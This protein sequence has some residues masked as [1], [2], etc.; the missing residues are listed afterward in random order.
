MKL[1][2]NYE[3]VSPLLMK[4]FKRGLMTN[5]FLSEAQYKAA[6]EAENLQFYE[7]KDGIIFLNDRE[8]FT[9]LTY[10]LLSLDNKLSISLPPKT[11]IE[12]VKRPND[13]TYND[14]LD[15]WKKSGFNTVLNR[16]RL[17]NKNSKDILTAES[18][19]CDAKILLCT[20]ENLDAVMYMLKDNFNK[21][22][23]C[24]PNEDELREI[25][26]NQLIVGAFIDKE[27]VGVLH[28]D[29]KRG[30]SEIRHLAVNE[31]F[32]NAS[33]GGKLISYYHN[34]FAQDKS[35][36]WYA[37]KNIGAEGVY[38]RYNYKVDGWTSTVLANFEI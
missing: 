2:E 25:V 28:F 13:T 20:T 4:Y 24:L 31:K 10:E 18:L 33:I 17:V 6:I 7:W 36:V 11:I 29:I 22:T 12:I 19:R 35:Y 16:I 38:K 21:Y 32:R 34:N 23:G 5:N 8:N 30:Y 9:K 14:V 3:E 37:E 1:I 26:K 27:L 15:Y